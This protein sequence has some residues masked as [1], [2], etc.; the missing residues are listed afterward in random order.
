MR[1][2]FE[3]SSEDLS[4]LMEAFKPVPMI[5][6]QCGTPISVQESANRAWCA[7]GDRLGF[8]GMTV[9]PSGKGDRFFTAEE[10]CLGIEVEPG[11]FSGCDAS[12]GDCPSCG[13]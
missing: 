4:Q 9:R 6:L 3:M 5:A 2:E 11:E 10:K 7:L 12:G 8:D 1:K 13:Q